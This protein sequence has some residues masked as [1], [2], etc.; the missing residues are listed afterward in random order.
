MWL[1]GPGQRGR[2]VS[3][4]GRRVRLGRGG[5][6]IEASG[7]GVWPSL[8]SSQIR[9]GTDRS[10]GRASPG[11]LCSGR[12]SHCPRG[13][14]RSRPAPRSP[15]RWI[16]GA[17]RRSPP[18]TQGEPKATVTTEVEADV[19]D[20]T[21]TLDASGPLTFSATFRTDGDPTE[22]P[23]APEQLILPWAPPAAAERRAASRSRSDPQGRR[24]REGGPRLQE[25]GGQVCDLPQGPRRGGRGRARPERP[26]PPRPRVGLSPA[27]RAERD[28]STRITCPTPS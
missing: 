27:Q 5:R 19:T 20:L 23:L 25:R 4:P 21:W 7:T 22:R 8:D 12:S 3:A 24:S 26:R 11:G 14:S 28:R 9:G 2:D 6:G 16:S 18:A 17:S 15:S 10:L 13:R 1:P